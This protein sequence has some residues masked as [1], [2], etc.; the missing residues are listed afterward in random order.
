MMEDK[1]ILYLNNT[2]ECLFLSNIVLPAVPEGFVEVVWCVDD[3]GEKKRR[4]DGVKY[5]PLYSSGGRTYRKVSTIMRAIWG[6]AERS[7]S[8]PPRTL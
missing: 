4:E 1:R 6:D 5:I 3:E 2:D 8:I 7:N